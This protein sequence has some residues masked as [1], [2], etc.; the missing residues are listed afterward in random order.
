MEKFLSPRECKWGELFF[1]WVNRDE[2]AF[3]ITNTP[4][5]FIKPVYDNVIMY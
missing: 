4:R 5:R 3:L 2:E 1:R